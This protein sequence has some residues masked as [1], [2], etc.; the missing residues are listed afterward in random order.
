MSF[1]NNSPQHFLM[2]FLT[3]CKYLN[4]ADNIFTILVTLTALTNLTFI[5]FI[6]ECTNNSK[7]NELNLPF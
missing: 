7:K 6:F 5:S 3:S 4:D 2:H 1:K